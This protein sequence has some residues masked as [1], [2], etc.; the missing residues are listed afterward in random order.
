[1]EVAGAGAASEEVEAEEGAGGVAGAGPQGQREQGQWSAS[2][3]TSLFYSV[4]NL[5]NVETT[6]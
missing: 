4:N 5:Y 3:L 6:C 2:I 1:M